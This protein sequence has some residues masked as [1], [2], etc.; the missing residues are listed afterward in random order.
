MRR[1]KTFE[2]IQWIGKRPQKGTYCKVL[3]HRH[4]SNS[5]P[6]SHLPDAWHELAWTCSAVGDSHGISLGLEKMGYGDWAQKI[7]QPWE[8]QILDPCIDF[9]STKCFF[10][11][12][13]VDSCWAPLTWPSEREG[14]ACG[15]AFG[16]V[17]YL[18]K[19]EVLICVVEPPGDI[20]RY[21]VCRFVGVHFFPTF[22]CKAGFL[23][24]GIS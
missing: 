2:M 15:K 3:T 10:G 23:G 12:P 13:M 6:P 4:E 21:P 11:Y 20:P 5:Q 7:Q 1:V 17:D 8:P 19:S 22:Q 9:P 24:L 14:L 18:W 16:S